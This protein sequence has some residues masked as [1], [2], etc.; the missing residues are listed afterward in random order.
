[1]GTGR[2]TKLYSLHRRRRRAEWC[3]QCLLFVAVR[4]GAN[5]VFEPARKGRWNSRIDVY[6][7]MRVHL[8][9]CTNVIY[10]CMYVRARAQKGAREPC[11]IGT[12]TFQKF[13]S[14]ISTR[15][16]STPPPRMLRSDG[17]KSQE[18][19]VFESSVGDFACTRRNNGVGQNKLGS[20]D[21]FLRCR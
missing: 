2:S 13:D 11:C 1:M 15:P 14:F 19:I 9:V 7:Y 3:V 5:I 20:S 8:C 10:I 16:Y 6:K 17:E 12:R 18:R 4:G 21:K